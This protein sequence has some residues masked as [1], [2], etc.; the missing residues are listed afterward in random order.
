ML[1]LVV[2]LWMKVLLVCLLSLFLCVI[3]CMSRRE[4]KQFDFYLAGPMRN[5][6][7]KNKVMFFTVATM[8]RDQG[9]TIFNPAEVNDEG[10][11]F[12]ECMTVDLDAVINRCKGIAFLPGWRDSLGANTEALAAMVCGKEAYQ[13]RFIKKGTKLSLKRIGLV[14]KTLP[15]KTKKRS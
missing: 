2:V 15:Y 3:V 13:T 8:L 12:E 5:Y 7:D 4:E 10:M 11:T 6:K 9:Y 14:K 1:A